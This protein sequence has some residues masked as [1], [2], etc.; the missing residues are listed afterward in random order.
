MKARVFMT[1]HKSVIHLS[2]NFYP[3]WDFADAASL[4]YMQKKNDDDDYYVMMV[5]FYV[6]GF[7]ALD[8]CHF[9]KKKNWWHYCCCKHNTLLD[10]IS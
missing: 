4:T 8:L 6:K 3:F 2:L 5:W 1:V 7:K 10:V 9:K